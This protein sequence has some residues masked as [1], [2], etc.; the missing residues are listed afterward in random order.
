[1]F[2]SELDKKKSYKSFKVLKFW[3]KM[4]QNKG[5]IFWTILQKKKGSM[6]SNV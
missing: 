3:K 2:I 6:G 1:M 4:L 5:L